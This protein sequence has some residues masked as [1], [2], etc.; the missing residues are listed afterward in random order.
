M[1]DN[2][3]NRPET[4]TSEDTED[5]FLTPSVPDFV[6]NP[7]SGV[8]GPE[9]EV[10]DDSWFGDGEGE[11]DDDGSYEEGDSYETPYRSY[12]PEDYAIE[13]EAYEVE[14]LY[15]PSLGGSQDTE[16]DST[17]TTTDQD[18]Q[19]LSTPSDSSD[20]HYEPLREEADYYEIQ[21]L[22]NEPLPSDPTGSFDIY[23]ET[24]NPNIL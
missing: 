8:I 6:L 5:T 10:N 21:I 24:P 7:I 22:E 9:E 4:E 13:Y 15:E 3:G 14:D 2:S 20:F 12:V 23:W 1:D 11:E 17:A 16:A 18:D 19:T